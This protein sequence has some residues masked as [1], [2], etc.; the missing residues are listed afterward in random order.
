MQSEDGHLNG[1]GIAIEQNEK[2]CMERLA[3]QRRLYSIAKNIFASQ[4]TLS[5][6]MVFLGYLSAFY[7]NLIVCVNLLGVVAALIVST[8]FPEEIKKY[9]KKAAAI[10]EALDCD[11]LR[12]QWNDALV[13]MPD[14]EDINKYSQKLLINQKEKADLVDW[15]KEIPDNLS[16][17]VARVI[18][19]RYNLM[20]DLKLRETFSWSI[21]IF[22][23][24]IVFILV[25]FWVYQDLSIS[26]ILMNIVSPALSIIIFTITQHNGNKESIE[27]MKRMKSL[28][29]A[30]WAGVVS[31]KLNNEDLELRSRDIQNMIY[32]CRKGN[33]LIPDW[34]AKI[35]NR[36][37]QNTANRTVTQLAEEYE[38]AFRKKVK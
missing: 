23:F 8:V 19:Q 33:P 13:S 37:Q 36:K 34:F 15:Y 25:M 1:N 4:F 22:S 10:Q 26:N 31:F 5:M 29:D 3:A 21:Q 2:K 17:S 35:I 12:I 28:I 27:E 30:L 11:L 6:L 14:P 32:L 24:V 38:D 9:K 18:C 20:W 7:T 16:Y